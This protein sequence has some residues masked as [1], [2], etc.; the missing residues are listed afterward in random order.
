[1]FISNVPG[2]AHLSRHPQMVEQ[3]GQA[4]Q[5]HV[6]RGIDT[7]VGRILMNLENIT[8]LYNLSQ[9]VVL[10]EDHLKE[11]LKGDN[12]TRPHPFTS[13]ISFL[14]QIVTLQCMPFLLTYDLTG[15]FLN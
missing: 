5:G 11:T 10:L 13:S 8:G 3:L 1:M 2:L 9:Q 15:G 7:K 6:A 12:Y 14:F 4:P